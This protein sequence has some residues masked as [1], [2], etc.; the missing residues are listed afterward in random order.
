MS[1]ERA[2]SHYLLGNYA[3][4]ADEVTVTDLSVEGTIPQHLTGRYLRNGPNPLTAVDGSSHHWFLG[5]GMV[6]GIRLN[7]GRVDWYRN[8]YVGSDTVA[9]HRGQSGFAGPNWMGGAIGPNTHVAGF[10]GRTFATMEA[11]APPVELSYELDS[12]A[13]TDFDGTLPNGYSGHPKYD[14]VTRGLHTAAYA[15]PHLDHVQYLIQ[16]P[17]ALVSHVVEVPVPGMTMMHDMSFTERYAVFYDQPVT[18]DFDMV[19]TSAFPFG[20]NPDYGN[21]VGF[22]DRT[23]LPP[24]R[25]RANDVVWVDVPLGYT[26]HPLNAFDDPSTGHV[27]IDLC[28]YDKMFDKRRNG[29]FGEGAARLERWTIDVNRR[30]TSVDVVDDAPNEFP[31][32]APSVGGRPYRFGYTASLSPDLTT[33]WPTHKHDLHSGERR[34][35]DH[36]P[37][38]ACGEPVFTARPDATAEDDGWLMALVHDLG[39][40]STE[41][42]IWDAQDF[43]RGYVA[44]VKVPQRVPFGFHGSWVND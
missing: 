7:Q 42:V 44:Q 34:V 23:S 18:V 9:L 12:V 4:I 10:A 11:G 15:W 20:W 6:H 35:F 14:P 29:P 33:G 32:H 17:D 2:D 27:V 13:R 16:S 19:A 30:T 25:S 28:R 37:G 22:L 39:T 3:P 8:R 36:G 26:F 40:E 5:D 24:G 43:D 1:L 41:F 21:R 38:R 31:Q